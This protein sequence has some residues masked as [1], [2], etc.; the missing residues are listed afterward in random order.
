MMAR[1]LEYL[2]SFLPPWSGRSGTDAGGLKG[3]EAVL[4]DFDKLDGGQQQDVA[5][6]LAQLWE[7]FIGHFGGIEGF[8]T[9]DEMRARDYINR[10]ETA[11]RRMRTAKASE[12]GH[13]FFAAAML[14]H[15]LRALHERANEPADQRIANR[16]VR[17]IDDG[18]KALSPNGP[19]VH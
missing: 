9:G 6:D 13:Y 4:R 14:G 11:A 15:Y 17:L 12:K 3:I 1:V 5:R 10:V 16:I 2:S 19:S 18:Q 8:L 7:A